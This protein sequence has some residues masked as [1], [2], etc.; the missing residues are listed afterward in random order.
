MGFISLDF[1]CSNHYV[2]RT[3]EACQW[4]RST[5]FYGAPKVDATVEKRKV[6]RPP[7]RKK[8]LTLRLEPEIVDFYRGLADKTEHGWLQEVNDTLKREMLNLQQQARQEEK[9]RRLRLRQVRAMRK[10]QKESVV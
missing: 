3:P 6:G 7:S 9:E 1:S 2:V 4:F 8:L 10:A 5:I